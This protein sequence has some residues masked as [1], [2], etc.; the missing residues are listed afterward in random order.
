MAFEGYDPKAV[1]DSLVPKILAGIRAV[2]TAEEDRLQRMI[3]WVR[4]MDL[5]RKAEKK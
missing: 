5:Y 1:A 2:H 4:A 3:P